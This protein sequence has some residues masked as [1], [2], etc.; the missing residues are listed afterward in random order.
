M[1]AQPLNEY[2]VNGK[3]IFNLFEIG[4][5]D[6]VPPVPLTP[7]ITTIIDPTGFDT[8]GAVE[9]WANTHATVT[10]TKALNSLSNPQVIAVQKAILVC[11]NNTVPTASIGIEADNSGGVGTY[12]GM[13]LFNDTNMDFGI[14]STFPYSGSVVFDEEGGTNTTQTAIKQGTISLTD[15]ATPLTT[16]FSP[17]TLTS[18]ASSAT[19]AD[20][21]SGSAG[22]NTLQEVLTAG[23]SATN[24]N[25]ILNHSSGA[26]MLLSPV[27]TNIGAL[28]NFT[29]VVPTTTA[30]SAINIGAS[31]GNVGNTIFVQDTSVPQLLQTYGQ[32]ITVGDK[33]NDPFNLKPEVQLFSQFTDTMGTQTTET[34]YQLSGITHQ[35]I[36]P[37]TIVSPA[38]VGITANNVILT[39]NN[40]TSTTDTL[41]VKGLTSGYTSSP[42]IIVENALASAGNTTGVPSTKYYKSGRT[43]VL[44]D[45]IMSQQFNAKNY[46]NVE[47]TYGKIECSITGASAITGDD[48]AL[49]FY[50]LINGVNQNVLRL[51][52]ADNENN[53]FRP[54][55]LNG[56]ALKTSVTNLEINST[57]STGTGQIILTPKATSNVNVNGD[58][59]M[60]TDKTIT[61]ND[62]SPNAV[63]TVIG[64]GQVLINDVTNGLTTF[65]DQSTFGIQNGTPTTT[66]YSI[67]G[68]AC[69]DNSIQCNSANGFYMNYGSPT[70]FTQLDLDTF[71][72][73]NTGG[74]LID[75]IT[76]GNNGTGNPVFNILS[77]DNTNPSPLLR[78]TGISNQSIG[79]TY[80]DVGA[81]T[82]TNLQLTD[83][84]GG[85]GQ[86][87]YTNT[88]DPT[89]TLTI[90]SNCTI[91]LS[92]TQDLQ[93]TGVNLQAVTSSGP[94]SQ[95]FRIKLNG[96]FYKI[97]LD[98]D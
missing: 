88:I 96:T 11:N 82:G 49:D 80:T 43:T 46:A 91:E 37:Y 78:Q 84:T 68:F 65:Q 32:I 16:S 52:G 58:L 50:T 74:T 26:S 15:T 72:M 47:K 39:S 8:N 21:I 30:Q 57:S 66:L 83:N 60:T 40:L 10:R 9:T 33:V 5:P 25:I 87:N 14:T 93:L 98:N 19:W 62:S 55:D 45:V 48:G 3:Q 1:A 38:N 69:N 34:K 86:L 41:T 28:E 53:T 17:T 64:N 75:Q 24:L 36:S 27:S 29:P 94:A 23:N 73:Y 67:N 20:I 89:Q 76:M 2:I 44:N 4:N 12:Y 63:Q 61:L 7:L 90:S 6:A 56:N 31:S 95:Y 81:G 13:N 54:F 35:S 51:N 59:L 42:N 85:S 70:N 97:A 18:G 92:T 22:D 77:T 79:F 71:E